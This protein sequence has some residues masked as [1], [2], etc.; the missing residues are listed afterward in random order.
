L[1]GDNFCVVIENVA[2][3]VVVNRIASLILESISKTFF[4][5][6]HKVFISASVGIIFYPNDTQNFNG[7]LKSS[8]QAMY[9]AKNDG[10]NF[11]QYYHR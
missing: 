4:I 7:L 9:F 10:R 6:D 5:G 8:D 1:G 3:A 2:K 11:C